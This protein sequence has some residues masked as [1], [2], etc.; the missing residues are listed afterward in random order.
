MMT[1]PFAMTTGETSVALDD[2]TPKAY[3]SGEPI[4]LGP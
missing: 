4:R 3:F 1:R 2:A